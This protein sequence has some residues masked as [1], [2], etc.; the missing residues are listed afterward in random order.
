MKITFIRPNL[1]AQRSADALQPLVFALL[2]GLTPSDIELT[3]LDERLETIP[4]VITTDLLALTVETYT[5]RRAYQIATHFRRQ[6]IPIVMGGYHPTFLPDEALQYADAVV[7][8]DAEEIWPRLVRDAQAGRLQRLYRQQERIAEPLTGLQF[9]RTI[10]NDK[11]YTP[12]RPVQAGRGC[13]FACDF[14]S[15]HAFYGPHLWR[16]PI[17]E[18]VAEI[19]ALAHKFIVLIDDNI[20]A[21]TAQAAALFQALIPLNIRWAG[22]VSIDIAFNDH[23]LALMAQSG[24][25][26]AV[27]GFESL[28]ERNLI[29]MKKRWNLQHGDYITAIQKFYDYGIM[30]YGTFVFGYDHDTVDTFDIALEFAVRAKLAL[31]NFNPLTPTPGSSLYQRLQTEGRLI[32]ECWWL[33]PAFRYGQATFHPRGMTAAELTAGCFRARREFNRYSSILQRAINLQSNCRTLYHLG[34]YLTANFISRQEIYHKQGQRL[35]DY[36]SLK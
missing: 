35:G 28:D 26:A 4:P 17:N 31:A 25:V 27:I 30:I 10:F 5:A 15:I 29:Q 12:L 6:G 7:I 34:I 23:L 19:E 32:Y 33:D 24:C 11:H 9:D 16:R 2:A 1:I 14:C 36:R 18:V 20:F 3:L 21:D 8:G 22:Q 13:R